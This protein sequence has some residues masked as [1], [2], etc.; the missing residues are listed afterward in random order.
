M[1]E[2]AAIACTSSCDAVAADEQ[3]GAVGEE[4]EVERSDETAD[5]VDAHDVERVVEAELE[6]QLDREGADGTGDEAEHDGPDRVQRCAG[7]GDRDETGDGTGC[8]A[9]RGGLAV[10]DL[11]DDEPGEQRGGGSGDRVDEGDRGDAVGGELG[12]G[13]EAEPAEPQQT[14]AEQHERRV[15][16]NV[17]ALLEA[18]ALAEH[19]RER[20]CGSTGVDVHRG[21]TGEVDDADAEDVLQTV[22]QPAAVGERAVLGE[23]EVEDPARDREVDDRRPD[24][25]EDQPG[26]EL[27]AVGDRT[28]DQR[29]GDDR[30]GRLEGGERER[31][32]SA[33]ALG[34]LEQRLL[35]PIALPIDRRRG[36]R[37]PRR[38]GNAIA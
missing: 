12:A 20:E 9:D 11:L 17:R 8:G 35:R 30:E 15:V 4:A 38:A 1:T 2:K 16:R 13:V 6:L 34:R 24:A 14:G 27:G 10:L 21:S 28:G 36:R 23:A 18:D 31:R 5:E 22:G 37:C 29:D 25:G 3:A 19:E 33:G 32:D 26:A 7:R